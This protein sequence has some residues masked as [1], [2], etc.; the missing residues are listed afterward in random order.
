MAAGFNTTSTY[1]VKV[2][3]KFNIGHNNYL[4]KDNS[5]KEY[6]SLNFVDTTQMYTLLFPTLKYHQQVID[7]WLCN[8]LFP[9]EAKEFESRLSMSSWDLCNQNE[10][11]MV[12]F[13]GTTD[14]NILLPESIKFYPMPNLIG[15]SGKVISNIHSQ[16]SAP[17]IYKWFEENIDEIG[18]LTKICEDNS[19]RVVLDVG[20]LIIRMSNEE[21]AMQLLDLNQSNDEIEACVFFKGNDLVAMEIKNRLITCY[22]I[23]PYKNN[24]KKCIIYLDELHCRGTDLKYTYNFFY[25]R[26]QLKNILKP[27]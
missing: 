4:K 1:F 2:R 26:F 7:Y 5:I 19:S 3:I 11:L 25:L 17:N 16:N 20:A 8:Y 14:S 22:E 13:S 23:S 27:F 10:N 24:L 12:G 18:M 21:V 9:K 6:S 15:T